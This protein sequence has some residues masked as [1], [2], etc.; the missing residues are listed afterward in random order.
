M[1]ENI[2]P[3][4]IDIDYFLELYPDLLCIA[5]QDGYL[6]RINPAVTNLLGYSTEELFSRSIETLIHPEDKTLYKQMMDKQMRGNEVAEFMIRYITKNETMVWLSWTSIFIE[7]DQL[8]FYI[9]KDI[10]TKRLVDEHNHISLILERLGEEQK[11]LFSAEIAQVSVVPNG[12]DPNV[13][14]LNLSKEISILDR[15]WLQKFEL[16]VR[17]H[18]PKL[19]LKFLSSELAMTERQ[20]HRQ[21]K[22]LM[23]VTPKVFIS[24][25]RFH[26]VWEAIATQ[27]GNNIK[28]LAAIAGYL[29]VNRFRIAFYER[30][31]I[32]VSELI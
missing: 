21:V 10:T 17:T 23:S 31:G 27:K 14:W 6:K 15:L 22:R 28:S 1:I 26:L 8:F 20:L 30:Y 9:G 18:L 13:G 24:K 2:I 3:D 29:N 19:D 32:E 11:Q 12:E 7:R 16:L 5:D 4:K 25:I